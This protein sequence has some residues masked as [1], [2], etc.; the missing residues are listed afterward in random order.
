MIGHPG[1]ALAWLTIAV[2]S[3]TA[4]KT[5][6]LR[7][8]DVEDAFVTLHVK[9]HSTVAG[10]QEQ[11]NNNNRE[12]RKALVSPLLVEFQ[13]GLERL[14]SDTMHMKDKRAALAELRSADAS[15]QRLISSY[16]A[17]EASHRSYRLSTDSG[18]LLEVAKTATSLE[19]QLLHM[20]KAFQTKKRS[21]EM[22][23][24]AMWLRL[25]ATKSNKDA[26][27]REEEYF[28]KLSAKRSKQFA[29]IRS[30][31]DAISNKD[32]KL[33]FGFVRAVHDATVNDDLHAMAI[34]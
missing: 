1:L 14:L 32:P 26:L 4:L 11:L 29:K 2:H 27:Q 28:N 3:G 24:K 31:V 25:S 9:L 19:T 6:V 33:L 7:A 30:A 8:A 16:S 34:Q 18:L 22:R 17:W 12:L 21:N 20:Q 10:L 5:E 13:R 23:L 15:L